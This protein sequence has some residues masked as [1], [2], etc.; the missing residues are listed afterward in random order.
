MGHCYGPLTVQKYIPLMYHLHNGYTTVLPWLIGQDHSLVFDNSNPERSQLHWDSSCQAPNPGPTNR[1]PFR[2]PSGTNS[3]LNGQIIFLDR[4]FAEIKLADLC[5][6]NYPL[7]PQKH[8]PITMAHVEIFRQKRQC[9]Y[10][11]I[12]IYMYIHISILTLPF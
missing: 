4:P 1:G 5:F 12:Y 3:F 6:W 2:K 8:R 11:Y 9:V 10:L 7:K